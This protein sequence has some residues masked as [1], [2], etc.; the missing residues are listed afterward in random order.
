M[1]ALAKSKYGAG[2]LC[3]LLAV[4]TGGQAAAEQAPMSTAPMCIPASTE[5]AIVACPAGA[6]KAVAK[7]GGNA[8]VSR[9]TATEPKKSKKEDKGKK[10]KKEKKAAKQAAKTVFTPSK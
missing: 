5:R 9:M 4:V 3:G 1:H 6:R 7:E 2:L 8:P 10:E